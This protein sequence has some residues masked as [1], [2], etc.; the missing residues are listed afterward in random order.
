VSNKLGDLREG[1]L[2]KQSGNQR[3]TNGQLPTLAKISAPTNKKQRIQPVSRT[4]KNPRQEKHKFEE[5]GGNGEGNEAMEDED[6]TGA[7]FFEA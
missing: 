3:G 6:E 7:G 5:H 4:E 2:R 1:R